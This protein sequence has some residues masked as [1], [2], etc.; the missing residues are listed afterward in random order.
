[1]KFMLTHE[2]PTSWHTDNGKAKTMDETQA[3][4][5]VT[6]VYHSKQAK[7]FTDAESY[8]IAW[9]FMFVN[10][11]PGRI[12]ALRL[13]AAFAKL[14]KEK[15]L[16]LNLEGK[17]SDSARCV[18]CVFKDRHVFHKVLEETLQDMTLYDEEKGKVIPRQ[19]LLDTARNL[20]RQSEM[21]V[22]L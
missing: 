13:E 2:P 16:L 10:D 1:M 9:E 20:T 17:A 3:V 12:L 5:G 4:T 19:K 6:Q 7:G 14:P 15:G 22:A 11:E 21:V 18:E 8:P